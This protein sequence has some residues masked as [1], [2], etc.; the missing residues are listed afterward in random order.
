MEDRVREEGRERAGLEI[1]E[2]ARRLEI[3]EGARRLDI[4]ERA[5][6]TCIIE[7]V[8]GCNVPL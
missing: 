3:L 7:V 4:L 8:P 6:R 1:L 2:R 5:R